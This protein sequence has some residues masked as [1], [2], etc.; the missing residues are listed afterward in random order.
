MDLEN[1]FRMSVQQHVT[2]R[3]VSFTKRTG[4]TLNVNLRSLTQNVQFCLCLNDGCGNDSMIMLT[5]DGKSEIVQ[6]SNEGRNFES[7]SGICFPVTRNEYWER[8]VNQR[9]HDY[10][11][12]KSIQQYVH[13]EKQ[14]TFEHVKVRVPPKSYESTKERNISSMKSHSVR[15]VHGVRSAS[16]PRVLTENTP[17]KWGIRSTFPWLSLI[18]RLL[19]TRLTNRK[20]R[21]W[22]RQT[23]FMDWWLFVVSMRKG[24]QDDY[25]RHSFQNYIDPSDFASQTLPIWQMLL[26]NG[27][28]PQLWLWLKRQTRKGAWHVEIE[29]IWYFKDSFGHFEK[30]TRWNTRQKF[31]RIMRWS[32]G[33]HDTVHQL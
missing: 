14:N 6:V 25:V 28:N 15:F 31:D 2:R 12:Q 21:W 10:E 9:Q 4:S 29:R 26:S 27:V 20:F 17:N 24:G 8:A 22:L 13:G 23:Q 11:R 30:S 16:R 1:V 18:T 33:R 3:N 32:F 7:D 5:H 19:Q